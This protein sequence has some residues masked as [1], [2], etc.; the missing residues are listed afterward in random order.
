MRHVPV[1]FE[2]H[3]AVGFRPL[4]W[5]LP[6][7]ELRCGVLNPRERVE[8]ACGRPPVLLLRSFLEPLAL[9][10]GHGCGREAIGRELSV[11]GPD[12]LLWLSAR[13][14][15]DW[16]FLES[17]V[18]R[19]EASAEPFA[20]ADAEGL[21]AAAV[22]APQAA[23]WLAHW[24][25]WRQSADETACW[26]Q[27]GVA[28]PRWSPPCTTEPAPDT[29]RPWRRLWDLLPATAAAIAADLRRLRGRLPR[30]VIWGAVP[31]DPAA[32]AW[33]APVDL[34]DATGRGIGGCVVG[35]GAD[36]VWLGPGCRLAA[37]AAIDASAGPVILGAGVRVLPHTYL[38]GPLFIGSGSLVKAGATIYGETPLGAVT[39]VAG[40]RVDTRFHEQA[41]RGIHRPRLPGQLVQSGRLT[42]N[43]DLKNTYGVIRVDHG[44]GEEDTGL[45]FVG[46]MMAEHG[47]TAIGTMF[48]T[49]TTVGF[50][51]NVF[52]SG[53]PGKCLPNWT[54][55]DG[56]GDARQDPDRALAT[57][58]TVMA[59]RGCELTDGHR[60]I[61]RFLG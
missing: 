32:A 42:T 36:Q 40:R 15:A 57:A 48:N 55:G 14:G 47:K 39:K 25:A 37:S 45:H 54:W 8:S 51:S 38:E 30:R 46:L 13:L 19:A 18:R 3:T 29:A 1:L 16:A 2:D 33:Q 28:A 60:E 20:L 49:G 58:R 17:V 41:A 59:R 34:A 9:A 4:S 11:G 26:R 43:S 6:V 5:S 12:G 31:A 35:G 27:P 21:L 52:G 44:D 22:P 23:S 56:R 50:A 53:F 24:D 61:F 10:G 7:G